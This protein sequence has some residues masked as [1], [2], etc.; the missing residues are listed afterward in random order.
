MAAPTIKRPLDITIFGWLFYITGFVDLYIIMR[1]WN[2]YS[3]TLFGMVFTGPGG[4]LILMAQPILHFALGYGFLT[5]RRWAFYVAI[6]YTLI[7]LGSAV[8]SFIEVGYGLIRTI[9]IVTLA[10][11]LIYTVAR[12]RFFVR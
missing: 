3:P 7:Y 2:D 1:H 8:T 9:F 4:K 5:L 12:R 11:F 6:V 10:P